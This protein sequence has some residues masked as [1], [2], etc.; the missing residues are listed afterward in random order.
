M[1]M[2]V[3]FSRRWAMTREAVLATKELW[4][5][6][7]SEFHC[8]FYDSPPVYSFPRP[9]QRPHPPVMIGSKSSRVFD[10]VVEYGNGWFPTR[11]T[12]EDVRRGRATPNELLEKAGRDPESVPITVFGL[13]TDPE[14]IGRF[15]D[16]GADR[17]IVPKAPWP[18]SRDQ[19]TALAKLDRIAD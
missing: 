1:V 13:S 11:V 5:K 8:E 4:T 14:V 7:A 18:S 15:E 19:N 3:D 9:A 10:R 16:A 12:P 6:T 2:G 17:V